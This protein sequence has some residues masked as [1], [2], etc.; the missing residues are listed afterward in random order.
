[1]LVEEIKSKVQITEKPAVDEDLTDSIDEA[2]ASY[3]N[4]IFPKKF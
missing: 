4:K 1:M 2:M 3:I